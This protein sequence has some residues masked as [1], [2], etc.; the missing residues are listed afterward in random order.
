MPVAKALDKKALQRD[1]ARAEKKAARDLLAALRVE[2]RHARASRKGALANA[3]RRCREGRLEARERAKA[4][5]LR[6]RAELRELL[7]QERAAAKATCSVGL[8][9]ARGLGTAIERQRAKLTAERA[10]HREM[11]RLEA[12]NRARTKAAAPKRARGEAHGESDDQVRQNIDPDLIPL[13]DRV[14]RQIRGSARISRTEAFLHYAEEH[15]HEVLEVLEDKTDALVRELEARERKAA[16]A[17]RTRSPR[18]SSSSRARSSRA[19]V[20]RIAEVHVPF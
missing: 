16:R 4:T 12:A 5:R 19:D 9:E 6:V 14:R 8:A 18:T 11:R 10:F 20:I 3:K 7:A 13:F 2:L 1:I 17:H 15:P